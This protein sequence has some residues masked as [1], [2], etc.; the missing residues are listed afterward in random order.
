MWKDFFF[1]TSTQRAG[2]LAL[3]GL[4]LV[5]VLMSIFIRISLSDTVTVTRSEEFTQ[6]IRQFESSLRTI[7]SIDRKKQGI[8]KTE[9]LR[10]Y[11][12]RSSLQTQKDIA[13]P[14]PFD[15]NTLDSLG[16]IQL[17]IPCTV[18]RTILR[19]RQKGG[20][21]HSSHHF[22]E[23]YGLSPD[24]YKQLQPFILIESPQVYETRL[25][26]N[27]SYDIIN[28]NTADSAQLVQLK[29]IG[30]ALAKAIIRFRKASGGFFS[31]EQ[32]LDVYGISNE[33]YS[34]MSPFCEVDSSLITK[35]RVNVSGV[36]KLRSH[37][38]LNF[39]QAK[40]IYELRRRKG[41]I[42]SLRELSMLEE[43]DSATLRK[44]TVYFSFE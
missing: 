44:M 22:S 32:L 24:L 9:F 17:G 12:E 14:F 19:F 41:K 20:Y 5:V 10:R 23:I 42:S 43:M 21:F 29:G 7:D 16:F 26:S 2:L 27:P 6:Q 11:H 39:Y 1:F 34:S 31:K 3:A 33:Q 40:A 36:D 25:A 8:Y 30:S 35:L 37:P 4:I 13:Q 15:P 18:V 28:L 38:Y